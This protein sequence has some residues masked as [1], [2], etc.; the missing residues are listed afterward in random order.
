MIRKRLL[1]AVRICTRISDCEC[2]QLDHRTITLHFPP[3]LHPPIVHIFTAGWQGGPLTQ[4]C[5]K[6]TPG[7]K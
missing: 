6:L 1:G 3:N 7:V 5:I 4:A 2:G